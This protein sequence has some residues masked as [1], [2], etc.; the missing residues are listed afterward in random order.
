MASPMP[1]TTNAAATT[2]AA[3]ATIWPV[4]LPSSATMTLGPVG[5]GGYWTWN[6]G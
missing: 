4:R 6:G 2:A 1:P 5:G 3:M